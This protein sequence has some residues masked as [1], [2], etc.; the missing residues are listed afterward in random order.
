MVNQRTPKRSDSSP[1]TGP[2]SRKPG[3][4][5]QQEDAGPQ[6]CVGVVVAVQRQP[7]ALQ[8][9]DQHELQPAA[10]HRGQQ[11]G[12]VAGGE[13]PVAE[14]PQPEHRL[15]DP[16]LDDGERRPAARRPP[17]SPAE[18]LRAGPAHGV[19]AV[20]AGCRR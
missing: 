12:G 9:D 1:D 14:Q 11:G 19:A 10:G 20:A 5:R 4:Q 13:G 6:R 17:I 15:R 8:P 2:A 18:H 7:D 3:G 16:G